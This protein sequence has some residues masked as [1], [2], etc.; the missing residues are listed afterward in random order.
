M[1][2]AALTL[3][4]LIGSSPVA[5]AEILAQIGHD[6]VTLDEVVATNPAAQEDPVVRADVVHALID[7]HLALAEAQSQGLDKT[8]EF[9]SL[10]KVDRDRLVLGLAIEKFNA[11]HPV[12]QAQLEAAYDK[13][14]GKPLSDEY[15]LREIIVSSFA[16]VD[17]IIA[18]IKAGKSFSI[19]A[20]ES[21][22]DLH[23]AALG[24]EL[25]WQ[26]AATLPA[27]LLKAV[28]GLNSEEVA[29]PISLPQGFAVVQLLGRRAARK[30]SLEEAKS[31]LTEAIQQEAWSNHI[32]KLRSVHANQIVITQPSY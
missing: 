13:A 22:E 24:G 9:D 25:G 28:S 18:E 3:L 8:P 1:R 19:L 23:S 7:R 4:L 17:R 21:S 10:L 20:A 6:P 12:T 27:P 31:Q 30:P 16:D 26:S 29:G 14:Y 2:K 15:R 5:G 32:A 11:A